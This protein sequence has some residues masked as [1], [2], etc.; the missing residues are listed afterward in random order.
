M[1]KGLINVCLALFISLNLF[2]C[3]GGNHEA[4]FNGEILF[5]K[6][7]DR[8]DTLIGNQIILDTSAFGMIAVYDSIGFLYRPTERD[9]QYRCFNLKNGMEIH[10][11]F[12]L[13]ND[14]NEFHNVTPILQYYQDGERLLS[15]FVAVNEEVFG[16]FDVTN[17]LIA[18]KTMLDTVFRLRWKEHYIEP[19]IFVFG[20]SKTTILAKEQPVRNVLNEHRYT[21]PKYLKIDLRRKRN[22]VSKTF[23]PYNELYIEN[24]GQFNRNLLLSFDKIKPDRKKVA[25]CMQ[26]VNQVNILDIETGKMFGARLPMN[27]KNLHNKSAGFELQYLHADVDDD[28]IYALRF[29]NKPRKVPEVPNGNIINVFDWKGNF[30]RRV[31]LSER[32]SY[33]SLD[34]QRKYLYGVDNKEGKIFR[35]NI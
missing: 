15:P 33:I 35:F 26:Y 3:V 29:D 31:Y 13:G 6:N 32:V 14:K 1:V 22:L 20:L 18:G 2:N 27:N 10:K 4:W 11:F 9:F 25:I 17:S 8:T 28:Y 24:A 30:V 5:I 21:T 23:S 34:S 19:F 7:L 16:F 12:P